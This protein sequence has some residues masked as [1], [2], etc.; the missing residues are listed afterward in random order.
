LAYAQLHRRFTSR[1]LS[2]I[3]VFSSLGGALSVPIGHAGN[4]LKTI[5]GV[6]LGSSQAL[7]GLHVLWLVLASV[8]VRRAGSGTVTGILKGLVE[9][10]L[11]SYHGPFALIISAIEGAVVDLVFAIT[12]RTN[13]PSVCLAGGLSSAS[14]VVVT[15]FILIP[16]LPKEALAFM[17]LTAF[18]SG[19]L[20][21][22]YL[23][24]RVLSYAEPYMSKAFQIAGR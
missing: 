10:T 21:A 2:L 13:T 22:G 5:P 6:P 15:Q 17:Y 18:I 8:L 3:I 24:V 12:K 20:F 9:I 4:F 1:E 16:T 11:F 23:V 7:S 19:S 14:N